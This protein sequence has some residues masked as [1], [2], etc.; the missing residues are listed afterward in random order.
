MLLFTI[1][2]RKLCMP[3]TNNPAIDQNDN[4]WITLTFSVIIETISY[5]DQSGAWTSTQSLA[6]LLAESLISRICLEIVLAPGYLANVSKSQ[7]IPLAGYG[8]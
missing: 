1:Y 4:A 6:L 2:I 8:C 5:W 7:L 3:K